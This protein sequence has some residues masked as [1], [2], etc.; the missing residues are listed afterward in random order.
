[1]KKSIQT[2]LRDSG[3][4]MKVQNAVYVQLK[5]LPDVSSMPETLRGQVKEPL[6]F[7]RKAQKL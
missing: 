3:W 5:S 7:I 6:A 4:E 1:M 2:Y